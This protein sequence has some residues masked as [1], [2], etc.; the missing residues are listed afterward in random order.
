MT[1][2]K[3]S[4][5]HS[6]SVSCLK[7]HVTFTVLMSYLNHDMIVKVHDTC[8]K[9][10]H[11]IILSSFIIMYG[12]SHYHS[13]VRKLS[14]KNTQVMLQASSNH[15]RIDSLQIL[16]L[17]PLWSSFGSKTSLTSDVMLKSLSSQFRSTFFNFLPRDNSI[18][19]ISV[20]V[21]AD[22]QLNGLLPLG[23]LLPYH[24]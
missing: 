15:S 6:C 20:L 16:P 21:I 12:S 2:C 8:C 5:F 23:K 3:C 17:I 18:Q 24:I 13:Q 22:S 7:S 9:S 1:D 4:A 14:S 10:L 19:L 11:C